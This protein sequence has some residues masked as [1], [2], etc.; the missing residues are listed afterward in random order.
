MAEPQ[1]AKKEKVKILEINP[2]RNVD[3]SIK[4][5][6]SGKGA[7]FQIMNVVLTDL[8]EGQWLWNQKTSDELKVGMEVELEIKN[9]PYNNKDQWKF[10]YDPNKK[11]YTG[12]SYKKSPEEILEIIR[13]NALS[14]ATKL[15]CDNL[16]FAAEVK[17]KE[18]PA[19]FKLADQFVHYIKTG[20]KPAPKEQ[21]KT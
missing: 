9:E 11:P 8:R 5:W 6:T 3:T 15:V 7:V 14:H 12:N 19:I 13:Q 20:E 2:V 18:V 16:S 21:S 17:G 1:A 10:R 4:T